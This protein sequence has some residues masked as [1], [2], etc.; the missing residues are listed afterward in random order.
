MAFFNS[1]L[2]RGSCLL[3]LRNTFLSCPSKFYAMFLGLRTVVYKVANL[4]KAKEWYSRVLNIT[5]YFDEPFYVGYNV[6][7]YELGLDPDMAD[8]QTGNN[9]I[10]YWGVTDIKRTMEELQT[11]NAVKIVEE[12]HNVGGCI[13]VATIADPFGN[14]IGL[15]E[16]PEFTI[17]AQPLP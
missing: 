10:A 16:N 8:V 3:T 17:D 12:P 7:G 11:T 1:L 14:V 15:I 5:P 13:W 6:G 4:Q 9:S 2:R